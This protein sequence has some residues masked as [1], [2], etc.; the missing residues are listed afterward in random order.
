MPNLD[1]IFEDDHLLVVNKPAGLLSV[2][3]RTEPYC[4]Q[5]QAIAY[6]ANIRVVHRLDM[7]TSGII[8]FAKSHAAQKGMGQLFEQRQIHKSYHAIVQG[9]PKTAS[10]EVDLPLICDWPNRPKQK[11]CFET[12]KNAKTRYRVAAN[13][14][15]NNA[16][17]L[18]L[19]PVTGRSH[20]LRVHCL[21]LGHPI[22]GDKLYNLQ[23][24]HLRAERL[25]LHAAEISF[26]HPITQAPLHLQHG[27]GF[28][29]LINSISVSTQ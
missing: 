24:S 7:A 2:P 18:H 9:Q 8:I 12:G 28:E 10:G 26:H 22:L 6:N 23:G 25:L 16:A 27:S 14:A 15:K 1:I 20:Q 11:V 21:A 17:L 29:T 4:L 5:A 19:S 3:G 13:C